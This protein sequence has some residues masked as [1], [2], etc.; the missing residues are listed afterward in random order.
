MWS[1]KKR[2]GNAQIWIINI[3]NDHRNAFYENKYGQQG[4][5]HWDWKLEITFEC[6][7]LQRHLS[8][9]HSWSSCSF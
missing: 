7:V 5:P 8:S 3:L 4:C 1:Q 6:F 2:D 9:A